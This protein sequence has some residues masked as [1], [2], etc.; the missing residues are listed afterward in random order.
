VSL[1]SA[2]DAL[3]KKSSHEQPKRV[4][5][6]SDNILKRKTSFIKDDPEVSSLLQLLQ[7]THF[8]GKIDPVHHARYIAEPEEEEPTLLFDLSEMRRPSSSRIAMMASYN[9]DEHLLSA[10]NSSKRGM[11]L[12]T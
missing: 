11:E 10:M 9:S 2:K 6:S 12:R 7:T 1:H 4:K 3:A 8:V 5:R